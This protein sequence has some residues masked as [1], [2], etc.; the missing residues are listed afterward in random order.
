MLKKLYCYIGA[1][2][3]DCWSSFQV[4]CTDAVVVMTVNCMC[5][6]VRETNVVSIH[7]QTIAK[8]GCSFKCHFICLDLCVCVCE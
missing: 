2:L 4:E 7:K 3:F 6:G 1:V 5:E 8:H